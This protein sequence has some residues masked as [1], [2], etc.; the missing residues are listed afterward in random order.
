MI[1]D[2]HITEKSFGDKTL[3]RDVKF[4]VDDGE[5]VGVVGRNGVGKSTLFGILA[6]TDTDYTGEVIFRRGITVASTAQEHHGLGDQTVLSYILAGL[7]EYASLKKIIDE[8]PETMGDNMRKIEE[9]TQA[10]ERFDQKGFYQIEEKIARELDNFQLSGCGERPLGSLSGGQKRLVEIVKIMHA[11]AHLALI[12]EPTNHMDYVAKQQFI[13]WMSSQPRQAMLIITHDRDVLGRVDRIV[14]LKDGQAVSYRGNYDA[15]LKQNAQATAAGMNNFEQVEKRITNLKQKVLDYQRLKEKSRNPGTIQ[16]F[17]RLE[18]EARAELA[19]LSEMDK[20]TFWIDKQSAGQLDYKSAERYGKFKAR[21][22]RLSMKDAASRSQH[23]LVRVEDA[24]VG[25]GERILFEGVNIDLR[26]GEAV[27][28]RGRNGAGK[29]TLIRMLL[30]QRRGSDSSLSG[31]S[32]VSRTVLPDAFDLE[33]TAGSRTAASAPQSSARAHSSLKSPPEIFRKRSAETSATRERST[34][35]GVE[36]VAPAAPILYS[37]N[38]FLDPQVRVGVYEQEIDERYLADPLQASI[39]KL[40]LSRDLP[41]SDTKIRQLLA[42][43][44]FTEADR[45]TPL[46]RLS[47]G[48]KARFQ[49]IAMLA[50]DPQLLILDEP[51]NHLDLPS[52]EELE[53]ALA[54]YS[55]AILYVSHDN[56]FRQEIGGEVVQ[57]GAA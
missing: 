40:Y 6:G 32:M 4:S 19:E 11:G 22:I 38:L 26:E 39:E 51:T 44:L 24:A 34:V 1:A 25:V 35:S 28:L 45:M 41:I 17:K 57:I 53:T 33:E 12:D 20:P 9:Y 43:Y 2:I 15:Y 3:M 55:G 14:E 13:D 7:P 37:G 18:H 42:D 54:K 30:G 50:N 10:L 48:Q 8:Y 5:K 29:T 52:I 16:K 36:G 27:E 31:K 21:N 23:V 56:Y 47:G 46:A 49:I